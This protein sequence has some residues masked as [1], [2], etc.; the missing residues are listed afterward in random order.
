VGT[1]TVASPAAWL[2]LFAVGILWPRMKRK[3]LELLCLT[4]LVLISAIERFCSLAPM[5]IFNGWQ[6]GHLVHPLGALATATL[7]EGVFRMFDTARAW[8]AYAE[9][10]KRKKAREE[11][12]S[13]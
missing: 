5:I 6:V 3:P 13:K 10:Q 4:P 9:E 11:G 7:L 1:A 8:L 12:G 2:G